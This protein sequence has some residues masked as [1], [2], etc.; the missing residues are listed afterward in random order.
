MNF[1]HQIRYLLPSAALFAAVG[2]HAAQAVPDAP[3][4]VT[5]APLGSAAPSQVL[6]SADGPFDL[7]NAFKRKPTVLVFYRGNWCGLGKEALA[8]VQ[9]EVPY[10]KAVGYQ[11]VAVSTDTPASLKPAAEKLQLSYPL[12]SD[13]DLSLS[14]AYGIAFRASRDLEDEYA[15]KGIALAA[16]PGQHG[17]AG[18]LVPTIFIVDTKG[19]I[20]WVYSNPKRNPTTSELITGASKAHRAIASQASF[21]S[22]FTSQP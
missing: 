4:G 2:L 11:V 7:G 18:L 19:V 6:P 16:F 13:H 22:T 10:L 15:R 21:G 3:N 20:R 8:E 1:S 14:S 5:P 17:A 9:R 12:L